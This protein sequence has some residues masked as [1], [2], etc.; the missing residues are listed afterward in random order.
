ME[1]D[2]HFDDAT[3]RDAMRGNPIVE[4]AIVDALQALLEGTRDVYIVGALSEGARERLAHGLGSELLTAEESRP[5]LT[6]HD[7]VIVLD[8]QQ[9]GEAQAV[10]NPGGM[11]TVAAVNSYYGAFL[12]KLLE[13]KG[14]PCSE[15][16][17]L[18]GVCDR[19]ENDG[20]EVEDATPVVVP[21]ALIPCDPARFP[22][23]V[24]AYLYARHPEIET[25]CYLLRARRPVGRPLRAWPT[26]QSSYADFPTLP[27]KTEAEW[28]EE[29]KA[30]SHC[31]V[32]RDTL[33]ALRLDLRHRD[34][35]LF[36][37][38][39]SL[40]W[41]VI[42]KYRRVREHLLPPQTRR[43]GF[44]ERARSTIRRFALRGPDTRG[45]GAT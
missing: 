44:Y 20:W 21:L 36:R 23:T 30:F 42:L 6:G 10:A 12:M 2:A 7:T 11:L 34:E 29:A 17:D 19:L 32:T 45:P 18:E 4:H 5:S 15:S 1:R 26:I 24:L 38:K 39:S 37:I 27:W 40:A 28:R 41:R 31:N 33:E 9:L 16:G 43:G 22:K 25:Y 3:I 13:G 35:E 8:A 14:R